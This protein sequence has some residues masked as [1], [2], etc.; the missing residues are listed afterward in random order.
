MNEREL[1]VADR[2][3]L[4]R[5]K[6]AEENGDNEA[7][8]FDADQVLLSAVRRYCPDPLARQL[9]ASYKRVGKWY[10]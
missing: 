5:M 1:D 3:L 6:R 4:G 10:A 7:A 2:R 8:H 9:I